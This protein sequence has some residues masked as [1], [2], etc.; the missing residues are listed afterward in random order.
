MKVILLADVKNLGRKGDL[1]D[2]AEGYA[3]NFL[4][5]RNLAQIAT[6]ANLRSLAT[7]KSHAKAKEQREEEEAKQLAERLQSTVV[8]VKA[9]SGEKGRLFGSVT[10][11]DIADAVKKDLDV[12]IDRKKIDMGEPIKALG[13]YE[14]KVRVHSRVTANLRV[15]VVSAE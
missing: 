13:T 15:Q 2:V 12:T 3:R 5:P 8:T 1:V 11:Q 4:I 10:A 9:K 14:L 6:D 7:E